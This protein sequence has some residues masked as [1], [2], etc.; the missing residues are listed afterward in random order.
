MSTYRR[1]F[2][3]VFQEDSLCWLYSG[4][5]K[6]CSMFMIFHKNVTSVHKRSAIRIDE[7]QHRIR[8][9]LT[10][11]GCVL[12]I[13]TNLWGHPEIKYISLRPFN[14]YELQNFLTNQTGV[15]AIPYNVQG[16]EGEKKK[17]LP[18]SPYLQ[19]KENTKNTETFLRRQSVCRFW[20]F[21]EGLG[22]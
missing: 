11:C 7:F 12:H 4:D 19:R 8:L 21:T 10:F 13:F 6:S 16:G 14:G 5:Y 17:Q 18:I 1:K 3:C 15:W 22:T 20:V 9:S 2:L